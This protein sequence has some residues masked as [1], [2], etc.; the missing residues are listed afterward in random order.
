MRIVLVGSGAVIFAVLGGGFGL[1]AA[2]GKDLGFMFASTIVGALFGILIVLYYATRYTNMNL[3][4]VEARLGVW[5]PV[6]AGIGFFAAWGEGLVTQVVAGFVGALF[7]LILPSAL[8]YR[9]SGRGERI[10]D[11][12]GDWDGDGDGYGGDGGESSSD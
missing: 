9:R 7:G 6:V 1:Y 12:D 2:W 8:R 5:V 11:S 3:G 10:G 4:G